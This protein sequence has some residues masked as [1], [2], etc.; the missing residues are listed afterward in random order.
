[1]AF[2]LLLTP[3]LS[4][5]DNM[6]L[7]DALLARARETGE[8]VLR[9][10]AWARPTLS[11]GR[12][13]TA[14]GVYAPDVL[15]GRGVDVVRRPTGGRAVL[16]HREVTY[17]VTAPVG[18][19]AEPGAA[20][21]ESYARINRVL[22]A[23][24]RALGVDARVATRAGRAPA[25]DGS[26]CF[27][28]PTRGE[29]VVDEPDRTAKLVGSAQWR[30]DGALL[31]HG[32]I[33]VDDDQT[34]IADFAARPLPSVRPP[35]TLRHILGRSPTLGEVAEALFAAVRSVED[36]AAQ[37]LCVDDALASAAR[38]ARPRYADDAW[39]WRR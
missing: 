23:A 24:L 4:G 9:A 7:D 5:A 39:T 37:P 15:A 18:A 36:P 33:L 28:R 35:A 3:P 1:M 34:A 11:F 17:S 29:L 32:S 14:R 2:R 31:Q 27:E 20:L 26:P 6:A 25:P 12:N 13:Q 22:I 10:Y 38:R 30:E 19:L 8:C 16:H 21:G